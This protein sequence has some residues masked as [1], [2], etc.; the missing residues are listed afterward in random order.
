MDRSEYEYLA[1]NYVYPS[2]MQSQLEA[3][4][5]QGWDLFLVVTEP[6]VLNLPGAMHFIWRKRRV[7]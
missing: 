5:S 4:S 2:N 7:I 3:C 6:P 1:D